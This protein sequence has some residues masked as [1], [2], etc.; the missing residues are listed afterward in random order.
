MMKVVFTLGSKRYQSFGN[1]GF[2]RFFFANSYRIFGRPWASRNEIEYTKT[3]YIY[4]K[5]NRS[6]QYKN[7][8]HLN[9]LNRE[10]DANS[11]PTKQA[12]ATSI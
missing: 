9:D 2:L 5:I 6:L 12:I 3:Q 8:E 7:F 4:T 11:E 1:F 10:C